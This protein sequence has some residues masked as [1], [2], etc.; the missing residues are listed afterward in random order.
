LVEIFAAKG[1]T[2]GVATS[3]KKDV[4]AAAMI[5]PEQVSQWL[6]LSDEQREA[7]KLFWGADTPPGSIL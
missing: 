6:V 2:P 1:V 5:Y 7:L 4:W 3:L